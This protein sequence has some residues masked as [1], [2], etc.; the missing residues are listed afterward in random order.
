MERNGLF[1]VVETFSTGPENDLFFSHDNEY[2][3]S[4]ESEGLQ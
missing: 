2:F 4:V 3:P 1:L